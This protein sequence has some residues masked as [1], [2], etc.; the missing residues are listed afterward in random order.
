[1]LFQNIK[2]VFRT[3]QLK[4]QIMDRLQT[5]TRHRY[6]DRHILVGKLESRKS[7]LE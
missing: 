2:S 4:E 1:M 6:A 5:Y 3:L 7:K